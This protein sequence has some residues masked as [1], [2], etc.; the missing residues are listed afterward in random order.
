[1]RALV[2]GVTRGI[3]RSMVDHLVAGGWEVAA[4]GRRKPELSRLAEA[5]GPN[6]VPYGADVTDAARMRH[7]AAE[8]DAL[9]LVVANAGALT[10]SGRFW[11]VD[12]GD[13]WRGFEVN[14]LGVVA[15]ARAVLPAMVSR[16]S[17]RLILMTSGIGNAPGP[18]SSQYAASKAA[19][20]RFGE[21]VAAELVGTGVRCFHLSPGMVRTD[22]TQWPAEL[23]A[24]R[25]ELGDIP[26]EAWTPVER[27]LTLLDRI[28][29][30]SLDD[31]S[32]RFLHATDDPE[33][34]RG[35][36]E[37]AGPRARTLRLVAAGED[38]PLAR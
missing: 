17:G 2:T 38:D 15:T 34:L 27:V 1:M 11:E 16:G 7:V 4:V 8:A 24:H 36:V 26:D 22:M 5:W 28:A 12:L 10:A 31:L 3:G 30:G 14:T 18:W 19:V 13:W 37:A 23:V 6:V 33:H 29:D 32:G 25:P 9:D 35:A 21:S 20:T